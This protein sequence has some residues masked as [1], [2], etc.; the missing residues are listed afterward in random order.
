MLTPSIVLASWAQLSEKELLEQTSVGVIGEFIGTTRI[1]VEENNATL[2]VGII[3]VKS[4]L[5][6]LVEKELLSIVIRNANA[7]RVS[8]SITFQEGQKGLWLLKQYSPANPSLYS[9]NHP[10]QFIASGDIARIKHFKSV[11][12]ESNIQIKSHKMAFK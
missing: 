8:T 10:Q 7:P 1:I 11:L 12:L 6:G 4:V 9:A 2:I 5:K 3:K